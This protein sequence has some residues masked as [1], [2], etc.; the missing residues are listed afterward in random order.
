MKRTEGGSIYLSFDLL[1]HSSIHLGRI[2]TDAISSAV[3]II[4]RNI[5]F[6][7]FCFGSTLTDNFKKKV[8]PKKKIV[9]VRFTRDREREIWLEKKKE[10]KTRNQ[11]L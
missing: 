10:D 4:H 1:N 2:I 9:K 3:L 7:N 5:L 6:L 11:I 8:S